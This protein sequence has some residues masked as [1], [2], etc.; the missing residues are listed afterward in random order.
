MRAKKLSDLLKAG[1]RIAVSNIT[2]REASTVSVA[3]QK[4][5][6]NIVGGWALGKV[7]G[8]YRGR[9]DTGISDGGRVD[10]EAAE[11]EAAQ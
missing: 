7:P 11:E 6:G 9:A 8:G 4:Y 5:C 2:G 1:D 10:Q 3:S